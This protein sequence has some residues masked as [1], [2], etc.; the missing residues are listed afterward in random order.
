MLKG[1]SIR[2]WCSRQKNRACE[3]PKTRMRLTCPRDRKRPV[4]LSVINKE[5]MVGHE[6]QMVP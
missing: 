5:E 3:G 2:P 4:C 1:E 6:T